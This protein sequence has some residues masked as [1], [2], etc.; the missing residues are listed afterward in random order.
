MR[1]PEENI[2]SILGLSVTVQFPPGRGGRKD[3]L[4]VFE[5][6]FLPPLGGGN[7]TGANM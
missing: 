1:V 4:I 2:D 7:G 3:P 6:F 5:G